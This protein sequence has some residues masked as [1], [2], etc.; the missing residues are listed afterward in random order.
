MGRGFVAAAVVGVAVTFTSGCGGPDCEG[1]TDSGSFV[2]SGVDVSA[3][4]DVPLRIAWTDPDE[5]RVSLDLKNGSEEQQSALRGLAVG[6]TTR[7]GAGASVTVLG[8]CEDGAW[9]RTEGRAPRDPE[10]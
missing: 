3:T 9:V 8:V 4:D 1:E 10:G 7:L 6:E 2:R 5:G